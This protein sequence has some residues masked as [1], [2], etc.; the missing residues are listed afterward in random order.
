LSPG[1]PIPEADIKL[2]TQKHI[3]NRWSKAVKRL[4][5]NVKQLSGQIWGMFGKDAEASLIQPKTHIHGCDAIIAIC[6]DF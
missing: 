3:E 4:L 2:E 6:P 5:T 1:S